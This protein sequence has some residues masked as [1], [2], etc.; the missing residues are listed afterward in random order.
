MTE[1]EQ[2]AKITAVQERIAQ[3]LEEEGCYL[4]VQMVPQVVI[5]PKPA[6]DPQPAEQAEHTESAPTPLPATPATDAPA[7]TPAAA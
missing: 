1:A 7:A 3:V 4:D 2:T 6:E 5:R